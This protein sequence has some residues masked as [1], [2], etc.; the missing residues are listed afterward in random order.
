MFFCSFVL[1]TASERAFGCSVG[2]NK[3]VCP[4]QGVGPD[5]R[6]R[7]DQCVWTHSGVGPNQCVRPNQSVGPDE[8]IRPDKRVSPN[9]RVR[10]NQGVRPDQRVGVQ[11]IHSRS[12]ISDSI[13][14]HLFARDRRDDVAGG[15]AF[16]GH[17]DGGGDVEAAGAGG[18]EA[19]FGHQ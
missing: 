18:D 14:L 5:Q 11:R 8:R 19:G 4:D 15:G 2:P 16:D 1:A 3:S 12:L 7:P 17:R 13:R 9:K 6:V 10:P